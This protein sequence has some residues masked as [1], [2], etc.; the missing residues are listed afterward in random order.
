VPLYHR[1]LDFDALW[2]DYP[3]APDYFDT[4]YRRSRDALRPAQEQRFQQQIERAWQIPFYQRLWAK[5]G[6]QRGD[7]RGL[8]DLTR[9]PTFSVHDMRESIAR[10]PPWGDLIGLDPQR[11]DPIPLVFQTSGG[12]TGLP[13]VMMYA[14]QDR[15]VMNI[16][17][18]RR[19]YMQGVRPFDL[20]QVAL[21]TGLPNAGFLMR[22]SLWKY[23]GA[24]PIISGPGNQTSTRRQVEL[25]KGWGVHFFAAL[26]SYLRHVA[27]VARDELKFDVRELKLKGLLSW[28]GVDDRKSLEELWGADVFDNYG[29]NELGT[30]CCDCKYKTGMHVFEDSFIVEIADP[31]TLETKRE[32]E[33]GTLIVTALFKHVAPMIRFNTND[34]LSFVSGECPCGSTHRR[35]S[36]L[37][38]RADNMVKIRGVNVFPEAVGACVAEFGQSNGEYV[39]VVDQT[40]ASGREE[41][42]IMV[43][44]A[45]L[46][47]AKADLAAALSARL[48]DALGVSFR[49]DVVGR[50]ELS[51]FTGIDEVMKVRRLIDRRRH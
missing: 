27:A 7:I 1:S 19:M 2:R 24:V 8:D 12:T 29:T 10:N 14:P 20:V 5:A 42:T 40:S 48:H 13:R 6:I 23:T 43:E 36:Q 17:T 50:G 38:G 45:D 31:E 39:C 32:G 49:V 35:L 21:A 15:E 44:A 28:L 22:E 41:M 30:V 51:R 9:L 34:V 11:D 18:A 3:P 37:F 26:G 47:V 4:T 46:S 25:M 16:N 33:R